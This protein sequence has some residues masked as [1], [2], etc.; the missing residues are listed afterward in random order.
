MILA[1][2]PSRDLE[3]HQL[4]MGTIKYTGLGA[5]TNYISTPLK[6]EQGI[7]ELRSPQFVVDGGQDILEVTEEPIHGFGPP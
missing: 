6:M 1:A 3:V 2:N 5:L 4:A 7:C